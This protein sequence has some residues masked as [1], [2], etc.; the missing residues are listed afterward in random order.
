LFDTYLDDLAGQ[1]TASPVFSHF[2]DQMD[3]A[4]ANT[5]KPAEIARDFIASMT[6]ENLLKNYRDLVWP[7]QFGT[8]ID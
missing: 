7:R 2:L 3:P 6:D 1:R 8:R 5:R 4:Y